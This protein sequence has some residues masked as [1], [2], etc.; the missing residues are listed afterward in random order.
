MVILRLHKILRNSCT[1]LGGVTIFYGF[2]LH[3]T[4]SR[5]ELLLLWLVIMAVQLLLN[6]I[7]GRFFKVGP[8]ERVWRKLTIK[9]HA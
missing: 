6:V 4:L 9:L 2:G 5:S 7:Y 3:N 1:K 8:V